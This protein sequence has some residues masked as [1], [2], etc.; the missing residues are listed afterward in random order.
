[1][2]VWARRVITLGITALPFLYLYQ[3][4][5][6]LRFTSS[7]SLLTFGVLASLVGVGRLF[8]K[9]DPKFAEMTGAPVEGPARTAISIVLI[10]LGMALIGFAVPGLLPVHNPLH[11]IALGVLVAAWIVAAVLAPRKID[12]R[13]HLLLWAAVAIVL[14]ALFNLYP[15][16][17]VQTAKEAITVAAAQCNQ[18]WGK[19]GRPEGITPEAFDW[20]ATLNKYDVWEVCA[21]SSDGGKMCVY[22][23]KAGDD[24]SACALYRGPRSTSH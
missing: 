5:V 6:R 21:F 24:H 22:V 19:Y 3:G 18:D 14:I 9:P 7:E 16:H 17:P 20:H 12:R 15:A 23:P 11:L 4:M 10:V 8:S 2:N 1:M 13:W